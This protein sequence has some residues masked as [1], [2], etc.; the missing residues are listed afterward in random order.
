[1]DDSYYDNPTGDDILGPLDIGPLAPGQAYEHILD[2]GCGAGRDARRLL[3]QRDRPKTYIGVDTNREMIQWCQQNLAA[4]GFTFVHHEARI[5]AYGLD[6]SKSRYLPLRPL[7]SDFTLI[8]ASSIFTHLD[9][10]QTEFYLRE[11]CAML[12]PLGIIYTTWFFFN[13]KWFPMM[14][15][16]H[17]TIFVNEHDTT[18]AVYYDWYYFSNLTRSLGLRIAQVNWTKTPGLDNTIILARSDRF[19]DFGRKIRPVGRVIGFPRAEPFYPLPDCE[20]KGVGWAA[21]SSDKH[22][23]QMAT[24]LQALHAELERLLTE[25]NFQN[26]RISCLTTERDRWAQQYATM[27]ATH[28]ETVH[29][30][31]A[32]LEALTARL[33]T[34]SARSEALNARSEV[35]S[36]QLEQ[37]VAEKELLRVSY[38]RREAEHRAERQAL[39]ASNQALAATNQALEAR[40]DATT[41]EFNAS[42]SQV[43]SILGSRGWR[44]LSAYY[45]FK[46]RLWPFRLSKPS[47]GRRE[48]YGSIW[49]FPGLLRDEH[50]IRK[51]GLFDA[52]W[53]L[54]QYPDVQRE[55]LDPLRHYL[56]YGV[57][58]GRDPNRRFDTDWYLSNNP[59]VATAGINPLKH[60]L[61]RGGIEQRDPSPQF[62]TKEYL[63]M[64]P[65]V[66]AA[67]LNPLAH[68]L[69]AQKSR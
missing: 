59:D 69:R 50:L 30:L 24:D 26:E 56:R 40:L 33:E 28:D 32:R 57:A 52:G 21:A 60:Y 38:E 22:V 10:D 51:S 34:L 14:S 53:Y 2:F 3:M 25:Q 5:P 47:A 37:A 7:G 35:L 63:Q 43:N 54:T 62:N 44:A 68:F 67:R 36:A 66:A 17:N 6:K 55:G 64:H 4:D 45:H 58:E 46:N 16:G 11:L 18:Q 20:E 12:A 65:E 29:L 61:R 23:Q 19:P 27:R 31:S 49:Q 15:D 41:T 9:E 13:K 8:Q 39:A 42:R 48:A 1:M